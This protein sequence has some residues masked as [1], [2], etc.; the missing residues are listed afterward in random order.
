M[1]E[2]LSGFYR[3]VTKQTLSPVGIVLLYRGVTFT[4]LKI[5]LFDIFMGKRN[6]GH[7]HAEKKTTEICCVDLLESVMKNSFDS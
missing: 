6:H 1:G 5:K 2:F 7:D 4:E 3:K